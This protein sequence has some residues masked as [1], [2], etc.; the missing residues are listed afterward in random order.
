ME[1]KKFKVTI[2]YA[3]NIIESYRLDTL[4]EIFD[5]VYRRCYVNIYTNELFPISIRIKNLLNR[6]KVTLYND[7]DYYLYIEDLDEEQNHF[8]WFS[9]NN[10]LEYIK[11]ELEI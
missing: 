1:N 5:I 11:K 9:Y 4:K 10:T 2:R 7:K 6:K 8:A 3:Y